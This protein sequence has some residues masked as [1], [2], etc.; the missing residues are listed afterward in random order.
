MPLY[1]QGQRGY[2]EPEMLP[3]EFV[4][5]SSPANFQPHGGGFGGDL[6]L[7]NYRVLFRP[8]DLG[9]AI[10]VLKQMM[11]FAP[12]HGV[13]TVCKLTLR[14]ASNLNA[15]F[16]RLAEWANAASLVDVYP[17][18]SAQALRMPTLVLVYSD[19][20]EVEVGIAKSLWTPRWSRDETARDGMIKAV[21]A[22]LQS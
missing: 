9:P 22:Q 17:G 19:R 1:G 3:G 13:G 10:S 20:S 21:L 12:G 15:Q 8:F 7:T 14:S 11:H 16:G 4:V 6:I 2:V 18:Q 5:K